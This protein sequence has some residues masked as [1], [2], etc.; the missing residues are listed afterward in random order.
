MV[1]VVTDH[2]MAFSISTTQSVLWD[3]IRYSGD[4]KEFAWVLPVRPGTDV[5]ASND[6][7]FAALESVSVPTIIGPQRGGGGG[8]SFGC[9][10]ASNSAFGGGQ[11]AGVQVVAEKVVGPYETVTLRSTDPNA[12]NQWLGSNG[13][14]I[15]ANIQ[16][17]IAAYVKEK[18]DFIAL[19]LRPGQGIRSMRPVRVV[20]PGADRS[21]PL[22][23]VAAGVGAQVAITL[24]VI[25][26]G[27]YRTQNFPELQIEPGDLVWDNAQNRSNYT[28][29]SQAAM[30]KNDGKTWLTEY[31][32]P[33]PTMFFDQTYKQA[34]G[35]EARDGGLIVGDAGSKDAGDASADAGDAGA[36]AGDA[37]ADAGAEA[38]IDAG[39]T[40]QAVCDDLVV[41]TRGLHPQDV[42]MTRLRANLP[43]A[44]LSTD[45]LLE[46]SPNQEMLGNVFFAQDN[47]QVRGG[48]GCTA[49]PKE[50]IAGTAAE[51]G[52][53]GFAL[54]VILRR[55]KRDAG[56]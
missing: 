11:D 52:A 1:T 42:W 18:F 38:G 36:D 22:R 6:A 21:L 33:L 13:Y 15:P 25:G 27:R 26:E 12:L 20:Y 24:F 17:T 49:S 48:S 29:L 35:A 32:R 41:A 44:A 5:E 31:A 34:C 23:M 14:A 30:G 9:S 53:C 40:N 19:K 45:L 51:I 54:L 28:E 10:S 39:S 55:K 56:K 2:R 43:A 4:P 7:W 3:Q 50:V 47:P 46:A 37:G 16:P 8:C